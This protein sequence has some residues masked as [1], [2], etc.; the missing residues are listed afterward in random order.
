MREVK[1]R[2]Q[3]SIDGFVA[4]PNGEQDRITWNPEYLHLQ[5]IYSLIESSDAV[6]PGRKVTDGVVID[7]KYLQQ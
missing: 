1:L 7:E 6:L 3:M 4:R 2:M 5:F